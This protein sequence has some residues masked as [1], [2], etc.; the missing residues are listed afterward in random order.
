MSSYSMTNEIT[1]ICTQV[2][3][4][5]SSFELNK[6]LNKRL[7]SRKSLYEHHK[8]AEGPCPADNPDMNPSVDVTSLEANGT[9]IMLSLI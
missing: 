9:E 3:G 2:N 7:A 6:E 8:F 4:S 5:G 1:N